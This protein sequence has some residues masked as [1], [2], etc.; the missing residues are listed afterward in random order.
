MR[1]QT[2]AIGW[3]LI[4]PSG[5]CSAQAMLSF[6]LEEPPFT[7]QQTPDENRVRNLQQRIAAGEVSLRY[8]RPY[9]YLEDLLKALEI[10]PSSQCLVFS[11]TSLQVQHIWRWN[12][13]AIYFNDDTYVGWIRGSNLLEI[14]TFDP[15][16]GT[17]FYTLE[18]TPQQPHLER[19][20]YDCL[21]CHAT[22]MTNGVPGHTVRSV[23]PKPDGSVV[24]REKSFVTSHAS[25]YVERWGGWY[26]TGN[27][28]RMQHMGNKVQQGKAFDLS[29]HPNIA[30]AADLIDVRGYLTPHSDIVAL[31]VLEHQTQLHNVLTRSQFTMRQ[32]RYEHARLAEEPDVALWDAT[33]DEL[34]RKIVA[35]LL[36]TDEPS[37][38]DP[39]RGSSGF[40][41]DFSQRGPCDRAG[42]SLRELDL[43]TRLLKYPCSPLVYSD[44]FTMLD[45]RLRSATL[46]R[47]RAELLDDEMPSAGQHALDASTRQATYEI[48]KS[49]IRDLPEGW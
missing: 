37:L 36:L 39:V 12:P 41:E 5:I 13:R 35:E 29:L 15:L 1:W 18:M 48:L 38:P 6:D 40:S 7:Y 17:A 23:F 11:K 4:L 21:G 30:S 31:L 49:T 44:A 28:G 27:V 45:A 22:A 3:F 25:P 9:G 2:L 10:D 20:N 19:A 14:S 24:F 47:L 8:R 16:L 26:V 42:R 32:L 33:V 46:V 43:Q 34:A